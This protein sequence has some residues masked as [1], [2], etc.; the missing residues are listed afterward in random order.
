MLKT[1]S[2]LSLKSISICGL[3]HW[4]NTEATTTITLYSGSSLTDVILEEISIDG[5][6]SIDFN[7]NLKEVKMPDF[8]PFNIFPITLFL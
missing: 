4:Y 3:V 1:N 8:K 2:D 7:Y 5:N 6:I